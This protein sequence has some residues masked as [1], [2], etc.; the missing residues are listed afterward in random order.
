MNKTKGRGPLVVCSR[1]L[2]SVVWVVWEDSHQRGGWTVDDP[3]C[4]PLKCKSVGFLV[5]ENADAV[6]LSAN[7]SIEDN[8]QRCGDMT[9]PRRAILKMKRLL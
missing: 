6:T 9:I 7:I 1:W 5:S 8:Q 2:G 4:H 3:Q